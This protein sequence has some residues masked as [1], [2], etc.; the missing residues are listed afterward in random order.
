LGLIHFE[1]DLTQTGPLTLTNSLWR[2]LILL[3]LCAALSGCGNLGYY[4]QSVSGHVR[5]M[6]AAR[7]IPDWM[8]DPQTPAALKEK[9]ALAQRLRSFAIAELALPDNA[10]FH[11]YADLH[12][13]AAIWNV[14]AAPPLSLQLHTW[15]FAVVGCIGYRGYFDQVDAVAQARELKAQGLETHVYGV[16]TYSTLGWLN[17]A[18]GD[19][20]LNTFITY[21]EGELARLV[22][23]ELAHQVVYVS[24]DTTFNESFATAVELLGVRA[25]LA[26]PSRA[27]ARE[28]YARFDQQRKDFRQLTRQT[29]ERLQ[30]LYDTTNPGADPEAS[31][32]R[33]QAIMDDFKARYA[34]L[35]ERWQLPPE[36]LAGYDRW[37]AQANNAAFGT[38]SA[39][40]SLVPAFEALFERERKAGPQPWPRFYDAVRRLAALPAQ[41]RQDALKPYESQ[42]TGD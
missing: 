37:V 36:R 5:L 18:G 1:C 4:W 30:T 15:C 8:A 6:Q 41:Q 31:L 42:A 7:P 9:L 40:D 35:R 25:W 12:R 20:L 23:H 32:R 21:P 22:F 33:K 27:Q 29:R 28:E 3:W 10:T 38:L 2:L 16:P 11:R 19:P 26:Q 14:T 39:Y 13:P 24:D 17:W 34:A